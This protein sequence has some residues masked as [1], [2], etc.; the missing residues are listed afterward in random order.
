MAK[1]FYTAEE[2]AEK[3]G[4]TVEEVMSMASSGEIQSFKQDDQEMFRVEQIDM[5]ADDDDLGDL[6]LEI[7]LEDS[8]ESDP[9]GLSGSAAAVDPIPSADDSASVSSQCVHFMGVPR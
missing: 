9:L 5:L 7:A 6:D 4:K 3:L 2:A 1:M 8:G